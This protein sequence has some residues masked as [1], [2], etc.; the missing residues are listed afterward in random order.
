MTTL[1]IPS[2]IDLNALDAAHKARQALIDQTNANAEALIKNG[3]FKE[4]NALMKE[5]GDKLSKSSPL[6][7]VIK[8]TPKPPPVHAPPPTTAAPKKSI[9]PSGISKGKAVAIVAAVAA[10]AGGI[11]LYRNAQQRKEDRA[12]ESWASRVNQQRSASAFQ[13]QSM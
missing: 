1:T 8:N 10:V 5:L 11:M 6:E 2:N 13:G 12:A 4:A 3:Q 9:L 7:E